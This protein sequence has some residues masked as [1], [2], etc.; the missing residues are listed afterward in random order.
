MV[1]VGYYQ[2]GETIDDVAAGEAGRIAVGATDQHATAAAQA[3]RRRS[4][5]KG[6][7]SSFGRPFGCGGNGRFL[8]ATRGGQINVEG[9]CFFGSRH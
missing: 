3:T 8:A 4:T 1:G 7:S 9:Q 2:R 6:R 5:P